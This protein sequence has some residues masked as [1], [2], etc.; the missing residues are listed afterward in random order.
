MRNHRQ[1]RLEAL[2][3]K[4]K[5]RRRERVYRDPRTDGGTL[6]R[7]AS[8]RRGESPRGIPKPSERVSVSGVE[9]RGFAGG[10]IGESQDFHQHLRRRDVRLKSRMGSEEDGKTL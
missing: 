10:E 2:G 4:E 9:E 5:R 8:A 1:A 7:E 3:W 6:N